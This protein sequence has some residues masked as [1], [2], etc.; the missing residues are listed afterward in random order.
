V[1]EAVAPYAVADYRLRHGTLPLGPAALLFS[2]LWA[3]AV[4]AF[5]LV[6]LLFPDGQLPSRRWRWVGG[7]SGLWTG[8]S[9]GPAMTPTGPFP[10]SPP[11]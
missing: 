6:V 8:G 2:P 5:G 4:V 1:T 7:C 10:L 3:A 11:V 9:T